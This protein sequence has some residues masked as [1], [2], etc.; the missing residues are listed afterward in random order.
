LGFTVAVVLA[1]LAGGFRKATPLFVLGSALC[2]VLAASSNALF[3]GMFERL[4]TKSD[5]KSN[6]R[7]PEVVENK[8]GLI[9]VD[10]SETV[11]GGGV[12]DGRFNTD[13][14]KDSNGI[15][16]AYAIAGMHARPT[17]VLMIGLS[18]GSWAQVIVNNPKVESLT[19]V[20][21]NPGYIQLIAKHRD[22]SGILQNPKVHIVID[23]GRR[24]LVGHP[25]ERFDFI[26]MNTSFSWRANAS[27]LLSRD[28]LSL[29][30]SHLNDSGIAYYNTT[31]SQKALKTGASSFPYALGV[32]NFIAVSDSPFSLDKERWSKALKDYRIEGNAVLNLNSEI[33]RRRF[34]SLVHSAGDIDGTDGFL[35]SRES[36]MR[37]LEKAQIITDDNMAS[38]WRD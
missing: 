15:F 9:T 23:D 5:Y 8:S 6:M 36:I 17:N 22:V 14:V 11:F 26:V 34:G 37:R 29:I 18:S 2:V 19:I 28:F 35:E 30:R 27:I 4:I 3:S 25:D 13:L 38:E 33:D 16:R 1:I 7:F 10:A 32:S 21:I 31:S 12:Y 20:E 24:W